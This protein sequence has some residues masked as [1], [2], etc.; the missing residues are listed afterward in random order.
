M[1]P[2]VTNMII[3]INH[4]SENAQTLYFSHYHNFD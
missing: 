2:K 1:E 3:I 4:T